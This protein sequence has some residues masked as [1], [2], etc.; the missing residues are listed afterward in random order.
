MFDKRYFIL[1]QATNEGNV[2][3]PEALVSRLIE[4]NV[5]LPFKN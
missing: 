3:K 4:Q 2:S 5:D 1:D